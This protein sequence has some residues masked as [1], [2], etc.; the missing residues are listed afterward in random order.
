[1]H[2]CS[3]NQRIGSGSGPN[4]ASQMTTSPPLRTV[5]AIA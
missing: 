5:A 1:M 3:F 2:A 4:R